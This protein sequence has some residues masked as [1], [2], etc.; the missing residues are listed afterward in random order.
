M[1]KRP[2]PH[3][4]SSKPGSSGDNWK[5]LTKYEEIIILRLCL[6][7]RSLIKVDSYSLFYQ[8]V[9]QAFTESQCLPYL[10]SAS[11]VELFVAFN[12]SKRRESHR[13]SK[14]PSRSSNQLD[15]L[16]DQLILYIDQV[17]R[18]GPMAHPRD[19]KSDSHLRHAET[20]HALESLLTAIMNKDTRTENKIS[21]IE[22]KISSL[23][24]SLLDINT[25]LDFMLE[26]L[27]RRGADFQPS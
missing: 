12:M 3:G 1:P 24:T 17:E 5:A 27:D 13:D 10:Y 25:K 23:E 6:E 7:F 18:A 16:L 20:A 8:S 9:A 19:K 21:K 11:A 22:R 26:R 14:T 2:T 15:E 4:P